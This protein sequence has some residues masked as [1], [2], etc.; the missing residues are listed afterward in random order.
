MDLIGVDVNLAVARSFYE[1]SGGL[2][3]WKPSEVQA[4]MVAEGRLGRKSGRGFYDYSS[5]EYREADPEIDADRPVLADGELATVAGALAPRVLP[6]VAAQIAN[7]AA[8]ALEDRVAGPADIDTAMRLGWNWPAGPLEF[9]DLL[10]AQRAVGILEELAG[11]GGEAYAVAPLLAE[12]AKR[13][14][15]LR[16]VG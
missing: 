1:Q 12:A 3:R 16:A 11:A 2:P 10:G 14:V 9:A 4:E 7:E 15:P 5:E 6:R 13:S 8:F